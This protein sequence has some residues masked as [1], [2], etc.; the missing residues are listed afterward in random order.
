MDKKRKRLTPEEE[1]ENLEAQLAGTLKPIAPPIRFAQRLQSRIRFP[2]R[3]EIRL[4]FSDWRRLFIVFS[5]VMSG[6]LALITLA[7]A[8]Y[9]LV[10]RKV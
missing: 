9:Y 7:R 8:F 6:M 4:R 1:L 2:D 5:G 3:A 10:G